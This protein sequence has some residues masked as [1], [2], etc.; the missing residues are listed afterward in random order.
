MRGR[1][2][3]SSNAH[4]FLNNYGSA[5][6]RGAQIERFKVPK[7]KSEEP[8]KIMRSLKEARSGRP[9]LVS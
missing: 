5:Q 9:L 8:E 1:R 2:A 7:A 4:L 6:T 3:Y